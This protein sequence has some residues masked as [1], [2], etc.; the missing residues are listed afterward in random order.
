[1]PRAIYFETPEHSGFMIKCPGC[2][3]RHHFWDTIWKFNGDRQKPTFDPS[4]K[5]T[6]GQ[7]LCHSLVRDGKIRFLPD[8]TH[9]LA[10]QTVELPY[11]TPEELDGLLQQ[12][13]HDPAATPSCC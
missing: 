9:T 4:M 12:D 2:Q 11:W 10:D 1:M 6:V 3:E 8:S 13:R 7:Q 5:V